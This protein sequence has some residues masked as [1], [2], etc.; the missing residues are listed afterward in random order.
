MIAI[1]PR[2]RYNYTGYYI[3]GLRKLF[4][5]AVI[6][7]DIRPFPKDMLSHYRD[8]NSCLAIMIDGF[9]FFIDADDKL[10]IDSSAYQW[11]DVYGKI[12][13]TSKELVEFPKMVSIGPSFGVTIDSRFCIILACIR[14]FISL[15][16]YSDLTFKAYLKDY[17]YS[18]VRRRPVTLY[19]RKIAV[20]HN[21]IF[22]ASTLWYGDFTAENTN[23]FRG[24]FLKACQKAGLIIEGG[25]FYVEGPAVLAE[26]PD[27]PKYKEIYK[28]FIYDKRLSM[29]YYIRKTKESVLVFNTP[30][31]CECHGWKL[32]EYLCMGKA[33]ISTPLTRVMPGEGLIHG[34]NVHFVKTPEEIYDAVVKIN[35]DESYRKKLEKG[36]REYYEKWLAPEVVTKRILDRAFE[37]GNVE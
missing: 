21:Y 8:N 23:M 12:N 18:F 37:Y 9:K 34:V 10:K 11:C 2:S 6:K 1:D 31:V 7:F 3:L 22:H 35:T 15:R 29:D 24:E 33:I 27:Y 13:V 19:E 25:L 26:M 28:D 36:A 30:S 5:R 20:K 32:A 16:H 17:I 4:P 14:N